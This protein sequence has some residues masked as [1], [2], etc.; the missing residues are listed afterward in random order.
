MST[1]YICTGM[2]VSLKHVA[3]VLALVQELLLTL[4]LLAYA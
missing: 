4:R 3:R 2:W 1:E